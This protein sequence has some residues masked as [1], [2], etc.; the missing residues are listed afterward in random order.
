MAAVKPWY[1]ADEID[2]VSLADIAARLT[3]EESTPRQW[4]VRGLLPEPDWTVGDGLPLWAW[5]TVTG[6]LAES[7]RLHLLREES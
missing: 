3:V 2:V 1:R 4:R 6:W 5:D 7:G